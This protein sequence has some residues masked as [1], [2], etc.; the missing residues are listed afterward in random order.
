MDQ[1]HPQVVPCW[2]SSQL[3]LGWP[4]CWKLEWLLEVEGDYDEAVGKSV[5][6]LGSLSEL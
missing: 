2:L 1:L 5:Q 4:L 3:V 6:D